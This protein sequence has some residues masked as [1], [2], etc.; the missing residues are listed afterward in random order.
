MAL[1]VE[2]M[3]IGGDDVGCVRGVVRV[4]V[5]REKGWQ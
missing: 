2:V 1:E 5:V 4:V 3:G